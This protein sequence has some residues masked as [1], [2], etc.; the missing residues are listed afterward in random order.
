[1]SDTT[2]DYRA[3]LDNPP[4]TVEE[5]RAQPDWFPMEVSKELEWPAY[6]MA[7]N[8]QMAGRARIVFL[9][10]EAQVDPDKRDH[11]G[12]PI[13]V[14][15]GDMLCDFMHLCDTLGLSFEYVLGQANFH[16]DHDCFSEGQA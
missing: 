14:Q 6:G 9:A 15:M 13:D 1:M 16:H 8:L 5:L 3:H 7:R 11:E 10:Y 4:R 12:E 2:P